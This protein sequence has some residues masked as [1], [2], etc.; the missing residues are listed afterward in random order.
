MNNGP[1][2]NEELRRTTEHDQNSE[3]PK[4]RKLATN[5]RLLLLLATVGL[6]TI[7]IFG[8]YE[9]VSQTM[10]R[11]VANV[12][13]ATAIQHARAI[14]A[15]APVQVALA[16]CLEGANVERWAREAD[17]S[18]RPGNLFSGPDASLSA[19][20][21]DSMLSECSERFVLD[22]GT[23]A[24]MLVRAE[25]LDEFLSDEFR[26]NSLALALRKTPDE[27]S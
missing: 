18:L 25:M 19:T 14:P 3:P 26:D 9:G 7:I 1:E 24:E 15:P 12:A 17:L 5:E 21:A 4:S 13:H 20:M 16:R 22:G 8:A 2:P 6:P 23:V 11:G 27:G 10:K